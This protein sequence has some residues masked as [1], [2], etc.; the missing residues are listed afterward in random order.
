MRWISAECARHVPRLREVARHVSGAREDRRGVDGGEGLLD[1]LDRGPIPPSGR[2]AADV[3]DERV[4][5]P[6]KRAAHESPARTRP[7]S[8]SNSTKADSARNWE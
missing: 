8:P 3:A 2:P 6:W 5:G 7:N 1:L 4:A